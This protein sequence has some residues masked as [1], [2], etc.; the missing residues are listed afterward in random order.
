[1]NPST[2][3]SLSDAELLVALCGPLGRTLAKR[4]LPEIFG[5]KVPRQKGLFASEDCAPYVVNAQIAVAKELYVR[6]RH[7]EMQEH[8]IALSTPNVVRDYLCGKIGGLGYE[9]FWVLFLDAQ[10]RL[11]AAEEMFRGTLTQTAV[12][13]REIVKRALE[14]NAASVVLAH[15]HP[16]T[17]TLPSMADRN[18]T[19]TLK[20]TLS[21][22][23]VRVVDHIIVGGGK[24][25]S[26]AEQGLI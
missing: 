24:T 16:S 20:T 4:P 6:A 11:I 14:L 5:F 3:A 10:N 22:V 23:D 19:S 17:E 26:F 9:V 18:L 7:A 1:M 25:L 13:P 12:H 21:L 2:I 15:N 8:G